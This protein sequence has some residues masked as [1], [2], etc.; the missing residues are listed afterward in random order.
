MTLAVIMMMIVSTMLCLKKKKETTVTTKDLSDGQKMLNVNEKEVRESM[1]K[2]NLKEKQNSAPSNYPSRKSVQFNKF[3]ISKASLKGRRKTKPQG[4][5]NATPNQCTEVDPF[6]DG[7][8]KLAG[9]GGKE[10]FY[11]PVAE[12]TP[13]TKRKREEA[14]EQDKEKKVKEGF[15]QASST[16][17]DFQ[18]R[19]DED[20]TLEPIKSLKDEETDSVDKSTAASRK[21]IRP[22]SAS[23]RAT[24][25][26]N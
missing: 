11:P 15:Y 21:T 10:A 1:P 22:K 8:K 2:D 17:V 18:S 12:P 5:N 9:R 3:H 24:K 4:K 23:H 20:D 19:S 16:D 25:D 13:S 26:G 14:L 6:N 7:Y